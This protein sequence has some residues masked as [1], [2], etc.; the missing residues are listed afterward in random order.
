M[1]VL[2]FLLAGMAIGQEEGEGS[3]IADVPDDYA[4]EEFL[5]GIEDDPMMLQVV[6]D[7]NGLEGSLEANNQTRGASLEDIAEMEDLGEDLTA[8][9]DTLN[10]LK[11]FSE[12][13]QLVS[14]LQPVDKRITRYCF[15]GCWCLP[16]G[17]HSFVA[18]TGQPVDMVDKSCQQLWFCYSCAGKEFKGTFSGKDLVCDP[19]KARYTFKFRYDP[20]H[21]K[22]YANRNIKCRNFWKLPMITKND[23]KSNCAR[24]ICECDR[25]AAFR[26]GRFWKHWDKE[27]HRIWSVSV[28]HCARNAICNT[29]HTVGSSAW[30][31]CRAQD[32]HSCLFLM[33]ERCLYPG[34]DKVQ[35]TDCEAP[36]HN[37]M[38]CGTYTDKG[39]RWPMKDHGGSHTCC[40]YAD[41][42][43]YLNKLPWLGTWYNVLTHCCSNGQVLAAGNP[44]C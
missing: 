20:V 23:Q 7:I 24:A 16:E 12:F 28:L 35:A 26:L 5:N 33:S 9:A 29:L 18:G 36:D 30:D 11:R 34:C 25:G 10:G 8:A 41:G 17:A 32:Q 19:T 21:P 37:E 22:I 13:K 44:S 42:T 4:M 14:W 3:N 15:Y 1:K 38:C 27:R 40:S 39:S 31:A 2:P 43:G 6:S